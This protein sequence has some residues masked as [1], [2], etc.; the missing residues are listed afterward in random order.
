MD[1]GKKASKKNGA[2]RASRE[3]GTGPDECRDEVRSETQKG[4]NDQC[5]EALRLA[6]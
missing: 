5:F 6:K 2:S 4:A 1:E 3:G